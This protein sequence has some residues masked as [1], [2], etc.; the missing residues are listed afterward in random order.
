MHF[1]L[2]TVFF[3]RN[4]VKIEN[5]NNVCYQFL[6]IFEIYYHHGKSLW[7]WLIYY[8]ALQIIYHFLYR[9]WSHFHFTA[10]LLVLSP[11]TITNPSISIENSRFQSIFIKIINLQPRDLLHYFTQALSRQGLK[12]KQKL[13]TEGALYDSTCLFKKKIQSLKPS[14]PR[15]NRE[16]GFRF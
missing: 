9:Q 1:L 10:I 12:L 11:V 6:L 14:V 16:V 8:E 4:S 13:G 5:H 3:E 15:G 2:V 7:I